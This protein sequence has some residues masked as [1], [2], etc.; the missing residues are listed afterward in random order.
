MW[1]RFHTE[2]PKSVWCHW[3]IFS[4]PG[5][6][7]LRMCAPLGCSMLTLLSQVNHC[8][9]RTFKFSGPHPARLISPRSHCAL[10]NNDLLLLD[11]IGLC[12]LADWIWIPFC[13]FVCLLALCLFLSYFQQCKPADIEASFWPSWHRSEVRNQIHSFWKIC[14]NVRTS[15]NIV[16]SGKVLMSGAKHL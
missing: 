11:V 8:M 13:L 7:A 15:G 16:V 6:L 14:W 4:R 3:S 1:R 5:D 9:W 2:N 12:H 10:A